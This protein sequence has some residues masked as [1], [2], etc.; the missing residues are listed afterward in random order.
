[1][2]KILRLACLV[3]F[4]IIYNPLS[5]QNVIYNNDFSAGAIGFS[6]GQANNFDYWVVNSVYN[7]STPT[8][9]NGGGNYLHIANDLEGENCAFAGFLGLG[10]SGTCYATMNNNISTA[11]FSQVN[12][13]FDW[14]C[15]GQTGIILASFGF[16]EYS[17]N[18]GV[19]WTLITNPTNQFAGQNTWSTVNI[20]SANNP[21]IANQA[22]LRLR[23]GWTN[24]GYGTNPAFSIDNIS[25][26]SGQPIVCD[27]VA[28]VV[29]ANIDSICEGNTVELTLANAVG[30]IQW[31]TSTDGENFENITNA[32]TASYTSDI[33]SGNTYFLALSQQNSCPDLASNIFMIEVLP[34]AMSSIEISQNLQDI[35]EGS[36]ITFIPILQNSGINPFFNW[37]INNQVVANTEIFT[38]TTLQN[39]D[40]VYC[41]MFAD[42]LCPADSSASSNII[43][44]SLFEQPVVEFN[45][46]A[47]ICQ[48]NSPLILTGNPE[49]GIFVGEGLTNNSFTPSMEPGVYALSYAYTDLNGCSNSVTSEIEVEICTGIQSA[50]E[51]TNIQI[52]PNPVNEYF[53]FSGILNTAQLRILDV[54]GAKVLEQTIQPYE[55]ISVSKL[56]SGFYSYQL[57]IE[58]KLFSGKFIKN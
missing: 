34:F 45:I 14:L 36:E 15:R 37:Y 17:T 4:C 57:S 19:S 58:G 11:G 41:V 35:C 26:T 46:P 23:F 40:Q 2:L 39:N 21:N 16:V 33:L 6:L 47:S 29:S 51:T 43:T 1:M 20:S 38:T 52:I 32:T 53:S 3:T 12:I 13:S 30:N 25:I 22:T 9:N 44:I 5:A 54:I 42:M 48:S 7:C 27:N 31:Q 55:L 18:N 8:P 24:S 50:K 49:G 10:S 28:G 56:P